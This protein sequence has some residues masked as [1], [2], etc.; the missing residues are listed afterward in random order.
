M[1]TEAKDRIPEGYSLREV[2]QMRATLLM[3]HGW[4][5]KFDQ[6]RETQACFLTR[7]PILADQFFTKPE[8]VASGRG[9]KTGLSLNT[10]PR[11]SQKIKTKASVFARLALTTNPLLVREGPIET[12][13][14]GPLRIYRAPFRS[15]SRLLADKGM[16]P[17]RGLIE[18]IG[19]DATDRVYIIM[20]ETPAE[21]WSKDQIV[22]QTMMDRKEIDPGF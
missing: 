4:F 8:D 15:G 22:A 6:V 12:K 19:N 16:P 20:F 11:V 1:A 17:I 13:K 5:Y 10:F 2:P 14:Q 21:L 18:G 7:E 3:P 9:F